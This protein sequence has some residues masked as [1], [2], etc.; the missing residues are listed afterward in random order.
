MG[1][2]KT[3]LNNKEDLHDSAV[4][5]L[6]VD[7]DDFALYFSRSPIP[8]LRE[9]AEVASDTVYY[10]HI[11]LYVYDREFLLDYAKMPQT[12][13]EKAERL[14]QLRALENGYRIKAVTT[15]EESIGV[16]TPEGL[17][18]VRSLITKRME[19]SNG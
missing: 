2:L 5:K 3:V 8:F 11:G 14:E 15:Q 7:K 6:V 13:L 19:N 10:K 12:P 18:K 17:E 1:T 16:D 4:A 9:D